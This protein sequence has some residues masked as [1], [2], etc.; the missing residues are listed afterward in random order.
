MINTANNPTDTE[1]EDEA[2]LEQSKQ[3]A[4]VTLV[5]KRNRKRSNRTEK[6][7]ANKT[8]KLDEEKQ[9]EVRRQEEADQFEREQEQQ[10][11]LQ[12]CAIDEELQR[13]E[14]EKVELARHNADKEEKERQACIAEQ[15]QH[16]ARIAAQKEHQA[17]IAEQK[18]HKEDSHRQA[19]DDRVAKEE[20]KARQERLRRLSRQRNTHATTEPAQDASV[21]QK[22]KAS[23]TTSTPSMTKTATPRAN[24]HAADSSAVPTASG[25]I[26]PP[27]FDLQTF[28]MKRNSALEKLLDADPQ[29]R[30]PSKARPEFQRTVNQEVTMR[31]GFRSGLEAL[32]NGPDNL[33]P[34]SD[35]GSNVPSSPSGQALHFQ[36]QQV[37]LAKKG[38]FARLNRRGAGWKAPS[39]GGTFSAGTTF[40]QGSSTGG[41]RKHA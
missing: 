24:S 16:R 33:P 4:P 18:Q 34:S 26:R 11:E 29:K 40:V 31:H 23:A 28:H 19:E 20:A 38:E 39:V 3:H 14:V 8:Q 15:K 41:I 6:E 1:G 5:H 37:P 7:D 10:R 35:P 32:Q 27:M 21:G 13:M 17:R 12:Q 2:P 9:A 36:Q 30:R 22:R 25:S